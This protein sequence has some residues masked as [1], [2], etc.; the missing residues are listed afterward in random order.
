MTRQEFDEAARRYR[1]ELFRLYAARQL[2]PPP[3]PAAPVPEAVP[4]SVPEPRADIPEPTAQPEPRVD[5]P[6]QTAQP[7]PPADIPEQTAQP[8]PAPDNPEPPADIPEPPMPQ[9]TADIAAEP[10]ADSAPEMPEASGMSPEDTAVKPETGGGI[11]VHVRTAGGARP[12]PGA[13]VLITQLRGADT[14]LIALQLTD[15]C[16]DTQEVQVPAPPSQSHQQ[17]PPYASYDIT[18][19]AEGYYRE[20]STDVPVFEGVVSVQSFDLIPLPA[21]QTDSLTGAQTFYNNMPR[22]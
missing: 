17:F 4:V 13:T 3:K 14:V 5:I 6:E 11:L 20:S 8:E 10:T 22:P 19:H 16:G 18:V 21:G 15:A 2:D 7:E 1:E 12:V 9:D